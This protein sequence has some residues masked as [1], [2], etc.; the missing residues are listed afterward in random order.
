MLRSVALNSQPWM[1]WRCVY[2]LTAITVQKVRKTDLRSLSYIRTV[3]FS[4]DSNT[5]VLRGSGTRAHNS[6]RPPPP[7]GSC[8]RCRLRVGRSGHQRYLYTHLVFYFLYCLFV[9]EKLGKTSGLRFVCG[10]DSCGRCGQ[11]GE[12]EETL[13]VNQRTSQ[14]V[15]ITD[16]KPA[17][18]KT[19]QLHVQLRGN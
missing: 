16:Q 18:T 7:L 9:K 19:H 12:E 3:E 14:E 2:I 17:N 1:N 4:F 10:T 8:D 13:I 15:S 6:C 5:R 11:P